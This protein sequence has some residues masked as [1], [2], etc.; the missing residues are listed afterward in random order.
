MPPITPIAPLNSHRPDQLSPAPASQLSLRRS[1]D[2]QPS[3]GGNNNTPRICHVLSY[4]PPR[5]ARRVT[6]RYPPVHP[7]DDASLD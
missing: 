3:I 2:R 4:T 1:S 5:S 7:D 6:P